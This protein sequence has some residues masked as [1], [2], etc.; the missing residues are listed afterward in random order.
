M[1]VVADQ[2]RERHQDVDADPEQCG[3]D[4]DAD[5]RRGGA[6]VAGPSAVRQERRVERVRRRPRQ[7][8]EPPCLKTRLPTAP[9]AT[10][11]GRPPRPTPRARPPAARAAARRTRSRSR[12]R[13]RPASPARR[14]VLPL[15]LGVAVPVDEVVV[16]AEDRLPHEHRDQHDPDLAGG[17]SAQGGGAGEGHRADQAEPGVRGAQEQ[18]RQ[19]IG[20]TRRGRA[21]TP[22]RGDRR[23]PG[24]SELLRAMPA[25]STT[26]RGGHGG[27]RS[28]D[29]DPRRPES[30]AT[31]RSGVLSSPQCR[32][33]LHKRCGSTTGAVLR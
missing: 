9:I 23:R 16:P 10:D 6:A 2:A 21:V 7:P 30:G 5:L 24:L 32:P 22:V 8:R 15:V 25:V 29:A 28:R 31:T 12:R 4:G 20:A 18:H 14:L 19:S 13:R 33:D 27:R 3:Q 1:L 17:P 26:A 11:A